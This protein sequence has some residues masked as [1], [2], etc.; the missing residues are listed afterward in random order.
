MPQPQ[1]EPLKSQQDAQQYWSELDKQ[2]GPNGT[3]AHAAVI[4]DPDAG[5]AL[6]GGAQQQ[7]KPKAAE[8]TP[9][10]DDPWAGV[11]KVVKDTLTDMAGKLGTLDGSRFDRIEQALKATVG[12]VGSIQSELAKQAEMHKAATASAATTPGAAPSKE[13][14]SSAVKDPEKWTRLKADFPEWADGVAEFLEARLA[15]VQGAKYDDTVLK[16]SLEESGAKVTTL[17]QS[18][19]SLLQRD[20]QLREMVVEMR[21]PGW[22]KTV[23]APPFRQW[24]AGQPADIRSLGASESPLD[25]IR[26]LDAFEEHRK[27]APDP[28]AIERERK[29]RLNQSAS[30]R[31]SKGVTPTKAPEDMSPEEYWKYLDDQDRASRKDD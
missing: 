13:Q 15:G 17:E 6:D 20:E 4:D 25:A 31:G 23:T 21:H 29:E 19:S 10:Q 28:E 5:P 2:E 30:I 12:R 1:E 11:P 3:P 7:D 14:I 22:T 8:G 16:K 9:P 18:V 27:K 24:L 26:L